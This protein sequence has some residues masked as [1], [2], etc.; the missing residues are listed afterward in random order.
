MRPAHLLKKTRKTAAVSSAPPRGLSEFLVVWR[1]ASAA[2]T[3]KKFTKSLAGALIVVGWAHAQVITATFYG[4]VT[5]PSGA[6]ISHE[7]LR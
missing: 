6:V 5:D 2:F 7:Q 3:L 4:T 1:R